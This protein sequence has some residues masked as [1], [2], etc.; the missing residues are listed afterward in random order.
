[1]FVN[2]TD[3][4]DV[5]NIRYLLV[6]AWAHDKLVINTRRPTKDTQKTYTVST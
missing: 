6:F 1:L 2:G 4:G 3:F 5:D